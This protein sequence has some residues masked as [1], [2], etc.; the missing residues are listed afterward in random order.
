MGKKR[1]CDDDV[2]ENPSGPDKNKKKKTSLESTS[3]EF[4]LQPIEIPPTP[5]KI[6]GIEEDR[7]KKKKSSLIT[8]STEGQEGVL[9]ADEVMG[10]SKRSTVS[11]SIPEKKEKKKKKKKK[12]VS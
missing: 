8:P 2:M 12:V 4:Q 7:K 11:E 6:V 5:P 10:N 3:T 9:P 1:K